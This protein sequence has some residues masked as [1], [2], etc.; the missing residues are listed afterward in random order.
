CLMT[1]T[2]LE[3][4]TLFSCCEQSQMKKSFMSRSSAM[5]QST[6]Q[7]TPV[8][9]CRGRGAVQLNLNDSELLL[10]FELFGVGFFCRGLYGLGFIGAGAAIYI[11]GFQIDESILPEF[12][13]V[14]TKGR[15]QFLHVNR[16]L[17]FWLDVSHGRN[18]GLLVIRHLENHKA[19]LGTDDIGYIT[20]FHG[21]SLIF[22]FFGQRSPLE[23]AKI[24]TLGRSGPIGILLRDLVKAGAL[25]NQ[26]Q[27]IIGFGLGSREGLRVVGSGSALALL[28]ARFRGRNQNFAQ[29]DLFGLLQFTLVLLVKL[30]LFL[31]RR[32]EVRTHFSANDFLGDDLVA[33]VLF[34]IL[35]RD[36]LRL[37]SLF[38]V[39]HGVEVHLLAHFV[40]PLDKFG[41]GGD[42]QVLALFQQQL[43]VDQVAKHISLPLVIKLGSV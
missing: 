25:L 39:F 22:Q 3:V 2:K 36:A 26:G 34:E 15:L 23:I 33:Q 31:L 17:Q 28:S 30:L 9:V 27:Q 38:Q 21:E 8:E 7:D 13:Q 14:G 4:M 10:L 6:G 41:I 35:V 20:G 1:T 11:S 32:G 19:L 16:I 5:S 29:A 37:C 24:A 42:S 12:G 18:A 40:Q 43:L